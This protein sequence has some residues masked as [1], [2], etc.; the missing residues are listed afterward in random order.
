MQLT[1]LKI[2]TPD[3]IYIDDLEVEYVNVRT[4]DG[5]ITV[6]ANHSPV[7]STLLIGDMKYEI[8]GVI[9]YIHLHRG[10]IQVSKDQV[11]ILTQRLYEVNEKGQRIKK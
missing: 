5:Q 2:I 3:E 1:K 6:Y 10:I 8:N 9:K 7:V 4:A 11:K